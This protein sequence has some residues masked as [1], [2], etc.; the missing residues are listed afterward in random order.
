MIRIAANLTLLFTEAPPL[1]RPAVAR[2]A[3]FDGVEIL[4]PYDHPAEDWR[5]ALD[6]LPLA[7]INLPPGDWAAGDRGSAALPGQEARFRDDFA[8]A[9]DMARS[10][11]AERIHVMAGNSA[12]AEAEAT[13]VENLRAARR[14]AGDLPLTIEPLNPGDMPG[15]FLADF[16]LAERVIAKLGDPGTRLQFDF[17]HGTRIAGDAAGL[18]ARI[19]PLVGHVQIAGLTAR[20]APDNAALRLLAKVAELYSGWVSAEYRPSSRT[21]TGLG[22]LAEARLAGMAGSGHQKDGAKGC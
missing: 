11:R 5:R 18:W 3:G 2:A 9:L 22:W 10:L 15:Y 17:W 13:F 19:A 21:S 4:F 1:E 12:G 20:E 14:V 6:G 8:R 16:D 7:L